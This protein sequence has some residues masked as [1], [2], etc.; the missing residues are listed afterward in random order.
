MEG[1]ILL[2]N[3]PTSCSI[4]SRYYDTMWKATS[5]SVCISL[6]P[7]PTKTRRRSNA[8]LMLV[9]RRRRWASIKQTLDVRL[10]QYLL[11]CIRS[12]YKYVQTSSRFISVIPAKSSTATIRLGWRLCALKMNHSRKHG[13]SRPR[14]IIVEKLK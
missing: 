12:Q 6:Q 8:C 9:Q 2:T 1:E 7:H 13:F 10:V 5:I 11:G 14:Q 3:S 4:F